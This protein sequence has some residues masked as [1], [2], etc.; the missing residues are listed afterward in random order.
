[1]TAEQS[2]EERDETSGSD[3]GSDEAQKARD[4]EERHEQAQETMKQ[5]EEDPPE[6]LEDWPTDAAKYTTFGGPEG[7]HSYEE[8]PEKKMGPSEVRHH[9]DGSVS[10]AGEKVDDP[11]EFKGEP[12][13]GGPTDPNAPK[14][15]GEKDESENQDASDEN[16]QSSEEKETD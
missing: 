11:D 9:E 6:K 3:E 7:D 12:I 14:L 1:M 16:D 2:T 10:V 15:S 5:L 4:A 13:P 8:G